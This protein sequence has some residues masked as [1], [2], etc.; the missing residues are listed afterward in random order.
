MKRIVSVVCLLLVL[1][2]FNTISSS[3]EERQYITVDESEMCPEEIALREE[4][5]ITTSILQTERSQVVVGTGLSINSS[6]YATCSSSVSAGSDVKAI[7]I[8]LYLLKDSNK[9]IITSW[10]GEKEDYIFGMVRYHQLKTRGTYIAK[11][12]I[13]VAYKDGTY[14]N[15]IKYSYT[16]TY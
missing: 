3:A 16:D 4:L 9:E 7:Q 14:D 6:G 1:S 11:A 10:M 15:F 5:G 13:Y 12:S 8:F 2:V